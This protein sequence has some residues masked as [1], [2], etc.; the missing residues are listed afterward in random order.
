MI[1]RFQYL[2]S[3]SNRAPNC[4]V[5]PYPEATDVIWANLGVVGSHAGLRKAL[6]WLGMIF[7]LVCTGAA[8][9]VAK[10]QSNKVGPVQVEPRVDRGLVAMLGFSARSGCLGSVLAFSA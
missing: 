4:N 6:A 5:R 3:I 9:V 8:V 7:L 2:L 10:S 1:Y